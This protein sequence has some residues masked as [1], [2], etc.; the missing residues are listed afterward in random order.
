MTK[1]IPVGKCPSCN[2]PLIY[3]SEPSSKWRLVLK[4]AEDDFQGHT[5]MC[6]KCK[7]MIAIIEFPVRLPEP[8]AVPALKS[9]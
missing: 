3:S 4:I 7:Q 2:H 5:V 1:R 9:V 8:I 6:A